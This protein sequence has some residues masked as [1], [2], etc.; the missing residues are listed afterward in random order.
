MNQHIIDR[1]RIEVDGGT[2][3]LGLIIT[4]G[5]ITMLFVTLLASATSMV[6][7]ELGHINLSPFNK[8]VA[9]AIAILLIL[10]SI[11]F[12]SS[13]ARWKEGEWEESRWYLGSSI[14]TSF[15][16]IFGQV[17]IW[18]QMVAMGFPADTNVVAGMIYLIAGMHLAHF[19][20]GIGFLSWLFYKMSFDQSLKMVRFRL[21]G[22]FWH[23]LTILWFI[24][25]IIIILI[26]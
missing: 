14:T 24:L 2:S 22:W 8:L 20:S 23:F 21:I 11:F 25:L 19:L 7:N 17:M 10:S 18:Q 6:L 15:L 16:F 9:F 3:K 5:G 1:G 12:E 13:F 26:I 4:F